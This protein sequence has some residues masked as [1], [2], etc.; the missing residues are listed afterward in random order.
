MGLCLQPLAGSR[1][2]TRYSHCGARFTIARASQPPILNMIQ[3]P[4]TPRITAALGHRRKTTLARNLVERPFAPQLQTKSKYLLPA[5]MSYGHPFSMWGGDARELALQVSPAF[6]HARASPRPRPGAI[7]TGLRTGA[8]QHGCNG[9][10]AWDRGGRGN[11][12]SCANPYPC[13]RGS[14]RRN[15]GAYE[16]RR[17]QAWP[18]RR[19]HTRCS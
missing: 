15:A 2:I 10:Y 17:F 11:P 12:P 14:S 7:A 1:Q 18:S 8:R 6:E 16:T 9:P 4:A 3:V 5:R 13:R 19:P